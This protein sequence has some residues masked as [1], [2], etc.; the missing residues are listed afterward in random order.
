MISGSNDEIILPASNF[1]GLTSAQLSFDVAYAPYN[2]TYYDGL[3]V[4]VS[5]DCGATYSSVYFKENTVLATN[6]AITTGIY[7]PGAWRNDVV[8]LDTYINNPNVLVMFRNIAGYGQ[9]LYIDNINLSGTMPVTAAFTAT[10]SAACIGQSVTY[11][12]TSSGATSWNWSF[13]VGATPATATGVG[14]HVVTYSSAG[15]KTATLTING[16]GG[17]TTQNVTITAAPASGTLSGTQAIC[18]GGSSTFTS[19]VTGGTWTSSAPG[20]ATINASSGVIAGI[21]AGTATMTYTVTGTGGC[22][23]AADVRTVTVTAP[24]SAGTLSG[25]QTICANGNT[26]FSSTISGG[27]WT[28]SASGT[29]SINPSTGMVTGVAGGSATM[30]YTVVGSGG[31]ADATAIRTVTVNA[32]PIISLGSVTQTT[33]CGTNT[34]S[35]QITGSGTGVVSWSGAGSGSSA[36]ITL[37][38]TIPNLGAGNYSVVFVNSNTCA[39]NT[40][41]Q[42]IVDPTPPTAPVITPNGATTFC[43]GGSVTLTSSQASGNTWSS[44]GGT[45]QS[46]SVTASGTYSV[47]Y[48][49]GSGCSATSASITVTVLANPTAPIISA[50]GATAFCAGG[51]ADLTS[52]E[53]TGNVWSVGGTSQTIAVNTAGNY[54]VTYTDGNGCSATSAPLA[55]TVNALPSAPIITAS[56][57]TTFCDGGTVN[58]TSSQGTGNVWSTAGTTQTIAIT[59][60]GTYTVTY[61]D[62]NGCSATSTPT[63]IIVNSLPVVA[64]GSFSTLCETDAAI[65]LSGGTP[66]GGTYSGSGVSVGTFDPLTAGVGITTI[67]YTFVDANG[68]SNTSQSTISVDDCAGISALNNPFGFMVFPNPASDEITIVFKE[69]VDVKS[70]RVNDSQGKLVKSSAGMVATDS[71]QVKVSDLAAGIYY[72][73]IETENAT[74]HEKIRIEK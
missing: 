25:N 32:T 53:S 21:A 17:T 5:T 61:T 56:G 15:T 2:G 49:N 57:P 16:S 13:G 51:S 1:M 43:V 66:A 63:S 20:T 28:S 48:T 18:S 34:G 65:T 10:P 69:V 22:P 50:G 29:A 33:T 26:T 35:I 8:N 27:T 64:L 37:P 24:P 19:T 58:L 73:E 31:C 68:C 62:G 72:L 38:Y 11:T 6:A 54:T 47:L 36:T 71:Y 74:L 42:T 30:T 46:I 7:V 23:N 52:S 44:G 41:S 3:E 55:V 67:T 45:A 59:T 9:A 70:I 14:P 12:S 40:L 4:L 60:A 39:S